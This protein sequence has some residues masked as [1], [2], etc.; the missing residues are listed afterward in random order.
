MPIIQLVT[1]YL[2]FEYLQPQ[3]RRI[4]KSSLV[5]VFQLYNHYFDGFVA[6]V[7]VGVKGIRRIGR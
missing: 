2:Q 4:E 6:A 3:P 1:S 7:D 5:F